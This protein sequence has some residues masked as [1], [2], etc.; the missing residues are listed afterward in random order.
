MKKNLVIAAVG[1]ES[2]HAAWL[3]GKDRS[4]DVA[5]VYFG[6]RPGQFERD[7]EYYIRRKGIKYALLHELLTG[8][9]TETVRR[10]ERVWLPDDD[11][12]AS[13]EQINL[14]FH[15]AEEHKLALC[16]PAI[17]RGDVS[18]KTLKAQP[19]YLLRYSRFVEM[20]CPLFSR[21]AL[22]R[23]LPTFISNQS[24]WGID[25]LWASMYDEQE[26]A[27]IDAVAVD[28]TRPLQSGGVHRRLTAMGVD[29]R[30]EH[31]DL[32]RQHGIFNRRFQRATCRGTSRLRAIRLDG[33]RV[34][35][36]TWLAAALNLR[37]A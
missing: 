7:A 37:A 8:E 6:D 25:W 21:E 16:Q 9:L 28:H 12:S 17:G 23:L 3:A 14:L 26:I 22:E 20:M 31:R 27:V 32:M 15:L 18:F 13:A 5:L 34:W 2:V 24:G 11:V 19:G 35:T 10:Y 30:Q 1:D 33:E 4:F 36:R 29:P